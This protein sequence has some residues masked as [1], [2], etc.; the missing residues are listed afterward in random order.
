MYLLLNV[1]PIIFFLILVGSMVG[2]FVVGLEYDNDKL[3]LALF[4]LGLA[5][6]IPMLASVQALST[7]TEHN[8]V[9]T[10]SGQVAEVINNVHSV[11]THKGVVTYTYRDGSVGQTV[12]GI[13]RDVDIQNGH[14]YNMD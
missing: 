2:M 14:P 10:E 8:L 3:A 5:M 7:H 13:D 11:N 9:V 6:V 4:F 1:A 12:L